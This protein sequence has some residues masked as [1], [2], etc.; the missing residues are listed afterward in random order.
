M[1]VSGLIAGAGLLIMNRSLFKVI[2]P[3]VLS[4]PLE[5]PESL[6]GIRNTV[7]VKDE[8]ELDTIYIEVPDSRIVVL[9]CHDGRGHLYQRLPMIEKL[10]ELG[11]SVMAMD[12]R[13]FGASSPVE[14][15]DESLVM[16]IKH[17]YDALHRKKWMTT[18]IVMYGQGLSA[19]IQG[20]FLSEKLCG[21]WIMDNPLPSLQDAVTGSLTKKLTAGRLS[22]YDGLSRFRGQAMVCYDPVTVPDSIRNRIAETNNSVNFCEVTG[23]RSPETWRNTDWDSWKACMLQFLARMETLPEAEI[24]RRIPLKKQSGSEVPKAEITD[25]GS[26]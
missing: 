12:Y 18:Q 26:E 2:D 25:H 8:G 3:E 24:P 5:I 21:G 10:R 22:L 19:G 13:G 7:G 6:G 9:Y 17:A 11:V 23:N 4:G 20:V 1:I 15:T 16:D 14:I